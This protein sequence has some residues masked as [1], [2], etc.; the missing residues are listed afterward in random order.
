[1]KI[2]LINP[3]RQYFEESLSL[4]WVVQRASAP[5][6]LL[7]LVPHIESAGHEVEILDCLL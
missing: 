6:G 5:I 2:L 1:M 3:N 4:D 7:Y